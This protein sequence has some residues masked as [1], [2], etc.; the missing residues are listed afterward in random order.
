MPRRYVRLQPEDNEQHVELM[1]V[2]AP[3]DDG[4]RAQESEFPDT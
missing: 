1:L 4:H 2:D 3:R